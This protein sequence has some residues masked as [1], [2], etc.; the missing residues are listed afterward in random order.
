[1]C[2][3]YWLKW[4][5]KCTH[6][7]H[8]HKHVMCTAKHATFAR[9][10]TIDWRWDASICWLHTFIIYQWHQQCV[11]FYVKLVCC[12]NNALLTLSPLSCMSSCIHLLMCCKLERTQYTHEQNVFLFFSLSPSIRYL[13]QSGWWWWYRTMV[14]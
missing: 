9:I 8:I 7:H 6:T 10:Q 3:K 2:E 4:F 5:C 1:M 13:L 12:A 11:H 14:R